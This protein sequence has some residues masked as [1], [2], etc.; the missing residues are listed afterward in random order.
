MKGAEQ[1][2]KSLMVILSHKWR[3]SLHDC[4][5]YRIYY[6]CVCLASILCLCDNSLILIVEDHW[7]IVH[8]PFCGSCVAV[9]QSSEITCYT[10]SKFQTSM[11]SLNCAV[12]SSDVK[13]TVYFA[14]CHI[15]A[16]YVLSWHGWSWVSEG[17]SQ[18]N[19][20][21]NKSVCSHSDYH[22]LPFNNTNQ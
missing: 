14:R 8:V 9:F 5:R 7:N 12:L 10:F 21:L 13:A 18:L 20:I 19:S 17:W 3:V 16:V 6:S 22:N 4:L 15:K 1:R 11:N 2:Q